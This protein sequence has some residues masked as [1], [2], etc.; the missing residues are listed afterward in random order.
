MQ[1]LQHAED[2]AR[3]FAINPDIKYAEFEERALFNH[4]LG[5]IDP[6]D[7]RTCYMV[8]VGRG[9]RHEYQDMFVRLPAAWVPEWRVTVCMAMAFTMKPADRL[10]VNL[11]VPSTASWKTEGVK[12]SMETNFPE[13][14]TATLKL[15]VEKPKSFTIS[16]RRPSWAESGFQVKV[17]GRLMT[18]DSKPGSYVDIR[19]TWKTGDTVSLVLPKTLRIEG[20]ADNP[21]R[22]ALMWGPLVLAGDLGPERRGAP[23]EPIPSFVTDEK[24]VTTWLQPVRDDLGVFRTVDVGRVTDGAEKQMEFVPF[25][26]LHRR[27]YSVYWDLYTSDTWKQKLAEIDAEQTRLRKLD[28]ATIE[29]AQ[30]GDPEKERSFNQ[31]GEETNLDRSQGRPGR[32]GKKWFSYDLAI[33]PTKPMVLVITY[34]SDERGKRDVEVSVDGLQVGKQSIERSPNGSAV[35]H[36]FDVEYKLPAGSDEGKKKVTVKFQ[37]VG[38]K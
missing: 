28:A 35:G 30:P 2:D 1:R 3:L 15:T 27:M 37:A 24:P 6:E 8:P 33:D 22:A 10:W 21:H 4:V 14:D 23:A 25:Y 17:N 18:G 19:R 36:F 26:K 11:F 5:S 29:F 9:V 7:G 20:L 34:N 12:L 38:W 31:Q 16:L 13:G 32:R